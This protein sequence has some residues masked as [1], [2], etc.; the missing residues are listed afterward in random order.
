MDAA[1]GAAGSAPSPSG[2]SSGSAGG[3]PS[4]P[5]AAASSPPPAGSASSDA[6]LSAPS[7][8][9]QS[10]TRAVEILA[11]LAECQQQGGGESGLGV[12]AMADQVQFATSSTKTSFVSGSA[13]PTTVVWP[14]SSTT[15]S[16][17]ATAFPPKSTANVPPATGTIEWCARGN[18]DTPETSFRSHARPWGSKAHTSSQIVVDPPATAA[19]SS[20]PSVSSVGGSGFGPSPPQMT[21]IGNPSAS[22][23]D[24]AACHARADGLA[25]GGGEVLE[26]ARERD[27]LEPLEP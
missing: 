11:T 20:A 27:A 7:R 5:S 6:G 17:G 12:V 4:S 18:G 23:S 3:S 25:M 16:S 14:Y 19:A 2:S 24:A 9:M 1:G 8:A 22:V 13:P 10:W 21:S 15:S 26:P